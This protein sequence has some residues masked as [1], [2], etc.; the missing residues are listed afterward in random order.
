MTQAPQLSPELARGVAAFA[1][2]LVAAAR[3]WTLYPP[4]HPA[5]ASSLDRLA[6]AVSQATAGA[7]FAVS[8]TPDS[9]LV[10]GLP[11]PGREQQLSEA[12]ALLHDRDI[13]QIAFAGEVPPQAL[14]A[15]LTLL[16]L[17]ADARRSGGGPTALWAATG[18][19][20]IAIEQ[21]DY[22]KVLEDREE[23]GAAPRRRDDVWQA[24]A[25]AIVEGRKVFDEQAQ[26]R[27]LA[28]AGDPLEIVDLAAAV[29]APGHA[30]DG[31]PMITTQAAT[32]LAAFRHLS[33]IV[34]V[35]AADRMPEVMRNL[36]EA[37]SRLDPHVVVQMLR[38]TEEA[39]EVVPVVGRLASAFDDMQVA[40]LL[41]TALATEGRASE[42]L[43][44][45]FNTIAPDVDR[46]RRVMTLTRSLLSES[47]FGRTGQFQVL[48]ASMEELLLSYD[49]TPYVSEAYRT[50]L[51]GVTARARDMA[52]RDLPPELPGWL[53]T[54]DR[55]NVRTLSV[56]LL[57]DLLHLEGDTPQGADVARD[58]AALAEDLLLSGDYAEAAR[59]TGALAQAAR[60]ATGGP[61][62]AAARRALDDIVDTLALREMVAML[63][64]LAPGQMTAV[65]ALAQAI[66]PA[67]VEALRDALAVEART[68][69]WT[70][71]ADLTAGFG[72]DAVSRLAPLAGDPRWVV[73]VVAADLLGRIAAPAGVPLLQ[74]LVRG[75]H[76]KVARA[77]V[78]ALAAI[79]DPAAARAL[80]TVL[81]AATGEVRQAVIGALLTDPDPRIVPM[82]VRI[83]HESQPLG[84]DHDIVLQTLGALGAVGGD[85]AVPAVETVMRA[86]SLFALKK[87]R[88]LAR[89]AVDTLRRIDTDA[90]RQAL[91][92]AAGSGHR[93]LRRAARAAGAGPEN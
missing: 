20:S 90:A 21:I 29:M 47:D 33:S 26:Q 76:P 50:T 69:T 91:G 12:A 64:D 84:A 38:S 92:Q 6:D 32:V 70:R 46:R 41:A 10:E 77:A 40:R 28:I 54:L 51:D 74:G 68:L 15:L 2:A 52:E 48:W 34:S 78:A 67:M 86:R 60:T 7:F 30:A 81:R 85:Q 39:G 56:T 14:R 18:H 44:E 1:R 31:S 80:H 57:I 49:E 17:D 25:R 35:M 4:E 37:A 59:V 61:L 93:A 55:D 27:L 89:T 13:L 88:T 19:P 45:V 83:L 73:Q 75:G 3:N 9:L 87:T 11:V 71:A 24:I 8:A 58:L 66:G 36:G 72:A 82:L 42:R 22:Q 63:G 53:E 79:D 23:S 43:A 16:A 5:V 65:T 62:R